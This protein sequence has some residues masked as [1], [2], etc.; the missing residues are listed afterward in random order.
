MVFGLGGTQVLAHEETVILVGRNAAGELVVDSDFDQPV[1]LP[2]SIYAG[3]SG[4]A[5]GSI[6][7]HSTILDEPTNDFFQLSTAADFEFILLAKDPG[8][9][10]WTFAGFMGTNDTQA[11]GPSPFDTH[12]LWN[13][14]N[15]TPGNAYSLTLKIRDLNGIYPD[16]APFVLSFTPIQIRHRINISQV[17]PIHAALSWSTNAVGWELQSATSVTATNWT[18]VTNLAGI[19]GT[20]FS[21]N[22]TTTQTKQFFRLHEQ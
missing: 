7:I 12:P 8:M 17:D 3:I 13:I 22:I 20:N 15:G 16:S 4:Y 18:T 5:T 14:A 9:E 10:I 6:G 1:E 2:V 21:L 11:I 19:I